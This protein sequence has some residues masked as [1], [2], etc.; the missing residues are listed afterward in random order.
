MTLR[1]P[2]LAAC[3]LAALISQQALALSYC[4]SNG[5]RAPWVLLERFISADCE[6]CWSDPKTQAPKQGELA[7]D[8]V[9]PGAKG[10]DAPL[11][12][13]ATRDANDRLES[14]GRTLTGDR[15]TSQSVAKPLSALR[16]RVAHGLPVNDYVGTSI[17]ASPAR[18]L[19]SSGQVTAW[20]LL[21]ETIPAGAEGSPVERNLVRNALKSSWNGADVL[22][23]S[24]Q[25]RFY[26]SRPMR[27]ANGAKASRLR[28]VGWL[29]DAS[30]RVLATAVSRCQPG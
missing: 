30:G 3:S 14:L 2:L 4:A 27:V 12:A 8:W 5:V 29:Q 15:L 9:L 17:E 7:L 25:K 18:A 23:K 16:L 28:V 19:R 20:L 11:S 26:E 21:V 10:D 1:F 24:E 13:V 22:S 6:A